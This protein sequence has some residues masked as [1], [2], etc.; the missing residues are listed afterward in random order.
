MLHGGFNEA[1]SQ[2]VGAGPEVSTAASRRLTL[3]PGAVFFRH[4]WGGGALG[5]EQR[6]ALHGK[7]RTISGPLIREPNLKQI[8]TGLKI[9]DSL[10]KA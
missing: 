4:T 2:E 1:G 10:S 8:I 9:S 7:H 3:R 5:G 6:S